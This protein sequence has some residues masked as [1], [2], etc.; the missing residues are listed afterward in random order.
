M[1]QLFLCP[2]LYFSK[3]YKGSL[4]VIALVRLVPDLFIFF[5]FALTQHLFIL[6]MVVYLASN[7]APLLFGRFYFKVDTSGSPVQTNSK[8]L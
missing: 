6:C 2:E 3:G 1:R 4:L 5:C 8:G 7:C